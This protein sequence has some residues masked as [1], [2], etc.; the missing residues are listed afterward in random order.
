MEL[1]VAN[2]PTDQDLKC[3]AVMNM[4]QCKFQKGAFDPKNAPIGPCLKVGNEIVFS[5]NAI[6]RYVSNGQLQEEDLKVDELLEWEETELEPLVRQL[7]QKS[8]KKLLEQLEIQ[9]Q[10]IKLNGE[11]LVGKSLSLADIVVGITLRSALKHCTS[12]K[13]PQLEAFASP[14]S[15]RRPPVSATQFVFG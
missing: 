15:G 12:S 9:L 10:N 13:F 11:Y 6:C 14:C 5:A 1:C 3:I 2:P 4:M 8:D 7:N